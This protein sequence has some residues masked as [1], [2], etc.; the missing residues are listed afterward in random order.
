MTAPRSGGEQALGV[1]V[2]SQTLERLRLYHATLHRWQAVHNLVSATTLPDL[3][4]RHFADC[5]QLSDLAPLSCRWIDMGAGAGFPGLVIALA[6]MEK[7]A[8]GVVELVEPNQR[9]VAFLREVIRLTGAPARVH[10][11]AIEDAAVLHVM[12]VGV[13]TARAF[14]N[15]EKLCG[16]AQP[17]V[18][19]GAIALFPKGQD[20]AVELTTATRYW[21]IAYQSFPSRTAANSVI[22]RID[23]LNRKSSSS[24]D[25]P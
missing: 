23:K 6:M 10:A 22:V 20:I 7:G 16:L 12:E 14:T 2:S 8:G 3:W 24:E 4:R 18:D 21:N 19:K 9:K 17:F 11:V 13:V 25:R 5:W 15:L 1:D